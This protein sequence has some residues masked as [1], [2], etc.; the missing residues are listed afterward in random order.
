MKK[1]LVALVLGL[2]VLLMNSCGY[3][4]YFSAI[5][6]APQNKSY[7]ILPNDSNLIGDLEF[8]RYAKMLTTVLNR[9]GYNN[10]PAEKA[11]IIIYFNWQI[12]ELSTE[13][14]SRSYTYNSY[15][16]ATSTQWVTTPYGYSYPQTTFTTVTTPRTGYIAYDNDYSPITVQ[17]IAVDKQTRKQIWKTTINDKLEY[18]K[19]TLNKLLPVMLY[20]GSKYFGTTAEGRIDLFPSEIN[21]NGIMWPY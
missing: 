7:Y 11:S 9:A 17:V 21:Q 10:V 1:I 6:S 3:Y 16:S 2:F 13:S 12:G 14:V 8:E 19:T 15:S 18:N 4:C 5:G 20:A